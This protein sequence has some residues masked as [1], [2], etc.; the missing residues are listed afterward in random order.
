MDLRIGPG[1][2]GRNEVAMAPADRG[3]VAYLEQLL[4]ELVGS[5]AA[6]PPTTGKDVGIEL[7]A[8]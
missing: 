5:P 6:A 3:P 2:G 4:G 7:E 1:E 8:G